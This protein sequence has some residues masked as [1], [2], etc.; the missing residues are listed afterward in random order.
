MFTARSVLSLLVFASLVFSLLPKAQ[1]VYGQ[2]LVASNDVAGGSSVFV[3]REG[4]K[5]PQAGGGSF[6][7]AGGGGRM[8]GAM[9]AM[10]RSSN[11]IAAV[12]K[13]RRA[14][15]IAARKKAAIAAANRKIALSNTLTAKAEGFLD[16]DQIDPAITNYKAALVQNPK[17]T[18]ASEGLSNALT[19]KGIDVAGESNSMAAVPHFEEAVKYDKKNDVAYA[20][21]GAIY[22]SAGQKDKAAVNYEKA[23]AINPEYTMLYAPLGMIYLD[24]GEIAKADAVFARGGGDTA[25]T[26][27]L[28]G[29]VFFKQNKNTEAMAAFDKAL[30]MD[31]NNAPAQYYRG[32]VFA[33][34]DQPQQA[35]AAYKDTLRIDP[36]YGPASFDLGVMYYN[37]G[38]YSNAVTAYQDAIK[39]DAKNYRAHANLA[40]TYRQ[41]ERYPEANAEYK[42]AADGGIKDPEM[43]SEWG[44]CLGKTNEWDKSVA[45]LEETKEMSP[46]AVDNS[47]LGWA[48]YNSGNAKAE[49]KNEEGAKAD[50]AM[51]KTSLQTA[52]EQDP[53]LDAAYLNLGSTHNKLGEYQL[54]VD[55][56]NVAVGR[57]SDWV[58]AVN[59]LG[60]GFRGLG[61]LKTA[62]NTFKRVVDLDGNFTYGLFNLGEA[63]NASGNKK[64]AKKINDRL[65]KIDP[66]LSARLDGIFSGKI[67]VDAA[68]QKVKQQ[69]P[70]VPRLPF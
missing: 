55:V 8:S 59:Q 35:M 27:Y 15:A 10:G 47:N 67:V 2:D 24:V 11:Q 20:K 70:S 58:I 63:Y 34:L 33:R 40:S 4:R 3:F 12:N 30:E 56:L 69:V 45:R 28:R 26:Q 25:E 9:G 57:R 7:F 23:L 50:Y 64:E 66:T 17:N 42:I 49:Q 14:D 32:Q 53:N 29:L 54:A 6:A 36:N 21:L 43:Y 51:A 41:L 65:R 13:K 22:D 5:K 46:T 16:K 61:D 31:S 37:A 19:S 60:I 62:V 18:R 1:P 39:A 48:Y 68:K 44:F 38:D 52:K